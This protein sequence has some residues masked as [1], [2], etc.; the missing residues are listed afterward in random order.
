MLEA[1]C[2]TVPLMDSAAA[3]L[4]GNCART[5]EAYV[6]PN[7]AEGCLPDTTV[8]TDRRVGVM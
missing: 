7:K 3:D 4:V 8:I 1:M 2:V 6:V 5:S